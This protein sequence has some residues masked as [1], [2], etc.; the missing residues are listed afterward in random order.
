MI[1]DSTA[2]EILDVFL[3]VLV[4]Y[5]ALV[6]FFYSNLKKEKAT[7]NASY[8]EMAKNATNGILTDTKAWA[9]SNKRKI[10]WNAVGTLG[11][12]ISTASQTD[13]TESRNKKMLYLHIGVLVGGFAL[14]IGILIFFRMK[15]VVINLKRLLI[16]NIV[17]LVVM[18][19][20]ESSFLTKQVPKFENVDPKSF[21]PLTALDRIKKKLPT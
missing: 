9:T 19:G 20:I 7:S 18:F 11:R 12:K 16:E 5:L 13:D 17:I 3:H 14:W 4:W 21:A 6:M 8:Q 2:N 1:S 10:D 15:G